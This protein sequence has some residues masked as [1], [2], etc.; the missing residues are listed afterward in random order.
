MRCRELPEISEFLKF[1][2]KELSCQWEIP[3]NEAHGLKS[4]SEI[5]A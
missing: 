4:Y 2:S 5:P 3:S 1:S